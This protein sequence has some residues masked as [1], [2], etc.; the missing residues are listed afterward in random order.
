M[1]QKSW[2]KVKKPWPED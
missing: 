2:P 1:D